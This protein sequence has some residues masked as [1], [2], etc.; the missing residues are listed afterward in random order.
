MIKMTIEEKLEYLCTW[1]EINVYRLE[2]GKYRSVMIVFRSHLF[3]LYIK[4]E[5]SDCIDHSVSNNKKTRM[6]KTL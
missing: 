3:N 5:L 6:K 1:W 4:M 2:W